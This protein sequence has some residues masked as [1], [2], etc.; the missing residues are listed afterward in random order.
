[1]DAKL[2]EQDLMQQIRMVV[3]N[4]SGCGNTVGDHCSN[5]TYLD[6]VSCVGAG[7]T[8][9]N[10]LN[11][12]VAA[13]T[14]LPTIYDHRGRALFTA[15]QDFG[16]E[17]RINSFELIN[18]SVAEGGVPAAGGEGLVDIQVSLT[19]S[20]KV[21]NNKTVAKRVAIKVDAPAALPSAIGSCETTVAIPDNGISPTCV[22]EN[23]TLLNASWGIRK[24]SGRKRVLTGGCACASTNCSG[25]NAR[26]Y[27]SAPL[28][29][30]PANDAILNCANM[31]G[32]NTANR[33]VCS[34]TNCNAWDCRFNDPMG[35]L[36]IS[37]LCCDP[38]IP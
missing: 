17:L 21:L 5:R 13:A 23:E 25:G 26:V 9:T 33:I 28:S 8:W 34:G 32:C 16:G 35:E 38:A 29:F 24:C 27:Q 12:T 14:A 2:A 4:K 31:A 15:P 19:Y 18:H 36:Y 10:G 37:V 20:K 3:L 11:L 22:W 6:Q 1:M 30:E 7:Q